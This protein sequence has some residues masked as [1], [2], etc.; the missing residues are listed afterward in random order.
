MKDVVNEYGIKYLVHFT[1]AKNLKSIFK[2]GLLSVDELDEREL[3][4]NYNDFHRY[5]GCTDGICLSI[6]FPNYRMFYKYRDQDRDVDWV[7]LGVKK[8]VLWKKE[9]A[10][11]IENAAS[12]NITSNNIQSRMGEQAFRRLYDE[13]PGKPSR[14]RLGIPKSYPT[15]P[16][17]EVLVF[18]NI[19]V[20]YIFGVAFNNSMIQ[21]RYTHLIPNNI[22]SIV[23]ERLFKWRKDF[24]HWR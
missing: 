6:Q 8:S 23:A 21:K 2:H 20:D 16:Q 4:Y 7:V 15:H 13:Y 17:A 9:C 14:K 3:S 1:Q 10:F 11:C 5:D 12:V 19:E 24:E 18:N 22:E